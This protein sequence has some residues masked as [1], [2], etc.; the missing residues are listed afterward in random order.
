ML[1]ISIELLS[2]LCSVI[3]A[4]FITC[5]IVGSILATLR[6]V[7]TESSTVGKRN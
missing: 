6:A 5:C 3:L 4:L 2:A 1:E 7:C